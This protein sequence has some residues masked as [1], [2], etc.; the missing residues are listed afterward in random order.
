MA[1]TDYK[2]INE[3]HKAFPK[4]VQE[5]MQAIRDI[6]HQSVPEAEEVISYQIPC[7]KYY[8]YL[9]YYSSS[10][11]HISLLSPWSVAFLKKF[12]KELSALKVSRAAIQFKNKEELP[13][14][15]IK[16]IVVFRKNESK[17]STVKSKK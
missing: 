2:T 6:I 4:A 8:G 1:K 9:I 11:N 16:R 5:R 7:F 12:E 17:P 10:A 15:L 14:G 13:V 3:Y